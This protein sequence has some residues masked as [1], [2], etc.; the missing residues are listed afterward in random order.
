MGIGFGFLSL[1]TLGF[2]FLFLTTPFSSTS[3]SFEL[4]CL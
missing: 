3:S 1:F 4:Y 2:E